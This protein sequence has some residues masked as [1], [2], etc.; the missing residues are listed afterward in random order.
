[1]SSGHPGGPGGAGGSTSFSSSSLSALQA[2]SE[3]V[4]TS[5]PS[6][7]NSPPTHKPDSCPSVNSTQQGQCHGG[8]CKPGS[9]DSKSPG[10]TLASG[11]E[12]Q[13]TPTTEVTP[14]SQANSEGPAGG[15]ANRQSHDNKGGHKK[16]L[17]LLTSPTEE[18]VSPNHQ[19]GPGNTLMGFESKEGLGGL[20]SPSTG[21]SSTAAVG[22]QSLGA[23]AAAAHFANQS[24]Q[25]K[26]KILHKLLQNGNTPDE[27]ARITAEA[28]GKVTDG[29]GP[30][31]GPGE[32]PG[33]RGA[34]VKQELHSPKEKTHALLHY[35]L[36]KD[37]SKGARGDV[38]PKGR[39]AQGASSGVTTSEPNP[40]VE[41]VKAEPP[42]EV[43]RDIVPTVRAL[44]CNQ[45]DKICIY[46]F[47]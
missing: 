32:G 34:E 41:Q 28:T 30:E 17:Q 15:E 23:A 29:G 40:V 42:D 4:G 18:L 8:P 37:D 9:S 3:G 6:P 7:L 20:T 13:H 14:D 44:K 46:F 22:Q 39:G 47:V 1:M 27:V 12:Q 38:Q 26:H 36:K 11:G 21:V 24:L 19:A 16:L 45:C 31:A 43:G 33:A 2:I 10:N 35:L 25:E 5:L